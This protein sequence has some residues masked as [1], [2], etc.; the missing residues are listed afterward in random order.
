MRLSPIRDKVRRRFPND[1]SEQAAT[2]PNDAWVRLPNSVV[3]DKRLSEVGLVLLAYR[4]TFTDTFTLNATALRRKPIVRGGGLGCNA[5]KRAIAEIVATGFLKRWQPPSK[6]KRSFGRCVEK[7]SLPPCGATGTYR[8]VW[9]KWFDELLS[10]KE[11]AAYLYLLAAT[12]KGRGTYARELASRFGWSRP[13]AAIVPKA[14]IA[15]G[16]VAKREAR[17]SGRIRGITYEALPHPVSKNQTTKGGHREAVVISVAESKKFADMTVAFDGELWV[18]GLNV[19]NLGRLSS[20]GFES[21]DWLNRRVA[22][23]V[24]ETEYD[25]RPVDTIII[26]P[27]PDDPLQKERKAAPKSP[28]PNNP[29][30]SIDDEI[31][32]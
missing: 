19:S 1:N 16:M 13:T 27:L 21:D 14:L 15:L 31:L 10:L 20:W 22:L 26:T 29:D 2:K 17:Q 18:V 28:K 11:K 32:F 24:G 3:R 23:D 12:G 7:L 6:G 25:A 30:K 9:R 5:I 4:A 8:M